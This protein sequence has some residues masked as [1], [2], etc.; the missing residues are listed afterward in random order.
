MYKRRV[1]EK[2]VNVRLSRYF[3]TAIR[4][5]RTPDDPALLRRLVLD[6]RSVE[7]VRRTHSAQF[8]Q[9]WAEL[10][11]LHRMTWDEFR[12]LHRM[13]LRIP[14]SQGQAHIS[15]LMPLKIQTAQILG[16]GIKTTHYSRAVKP[17]TVPMATG[18]QSS[19]KGID[20]PSGRGVDSAVVTPNTSAEEQGPAA[21]LE[22]PAQDSGISASL[23]KF[24]KRYLSARAPSVIALGAKF[25]IVACIDIAPAPEGSSAPLA[26]VAI[27]KNGLMVTI[28]T[29]VE[30]ELKLLGSA[31][32]QVR[33]LPGKKSSTIE[34]DLQAAALGSASAVL[35]ARTEQA[36]LG[37]LRIGILVANKGAPDLQDVKSGIVATTP[38]ARRATLTITYSRPGRIYRFMLLG[39][40]AGTHE[41]E[42]VL[43][44]D[45]DTLVPKLM[46]QANELTRGTAGYSKEAVE[47]V[48][49]GIGSEMWSRL[50][51]DRIKVVLARCW[52][53]ID[54]LDIVS[55]DDMLPWELLFAF[56]PGGPLMGFISDRWLVTRWRFGEG[57]PI[58]VGS[59]PPVY[60][61]PAEAPPAAHDEIDTLQGIFPSDAVWKTVDELNK[62]IRRAGM[63]LLHIAAHNNICYGD[64]AAS[65]ISLD[66]PF[67]QS[68]LGPHLEGVLEHMPLVF[69]N[70]CASAAPTVQWLGGT[71]WAARFLKAGAGAFI[72]SNWEVRDETALIFAKEFY[73]QARLNQP[74]GAAFQRA[75]TKCGGPGDP[76]RF[77]YSF[78]G[79]PDAVLQT[80]GAD[81]P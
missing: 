27:P 20:Q 68:M 49:I 70:A 47:A 66:K 11:K 1:E 78:F 48:L 8:Q 42:L 45:L 56:S 64:A 67:L 73:E 3:E 81:T 41:A 39:D 74:L 18:R 52:D 25:S 59:G 37:D 75:R 71:S 58:D 17:Y 46:A 6:F 29:L 69:I 2:L 40:A 4:H 31:S 9:A 28:E 23:P 77:A 36:Y 21:G 60:V 44:E 57:A 7:Q 55:N 51:P 14:R 53:G 34:I 13:S 22:T 79:H 15:R 63:G 54:R 62:G 50:L 35:R 38:V 30:G 32:L 33:V 61:I 10:T 12:E 65:F 76:T 16:R 5:A 26:E 72:G 19:L 24:E 80:Q 43:D